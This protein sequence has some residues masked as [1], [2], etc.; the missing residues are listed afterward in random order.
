MKDGAMMLWKVAVAGG[1]VALTP[2]TA[3]GMA[4]G[5][6]VAQPQPTAI[7]TLGVGAKVH[8]GVHSTGAAVRWGHGIGPS[9]R[10]WR[11]LA[12]LLCTQGTVGLVRQTYKRFGFTETLALG[13][14]GL[15]E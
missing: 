13:R 4:I 6:Q 7:V 1:T 11:S 14:D 3:A 9:W 12:S 8:G 5:P 2:W 10:R 15:G